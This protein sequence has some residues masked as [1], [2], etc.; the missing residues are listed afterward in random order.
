MLS[1][2]KAVLEF[3]EADDNKGAAAA[4]IVAGGSS[5]RMKGI[6]KITSG[7]LGVPVIARTLRAFQNSES[8]NKIILVA[9]REDIPQMQIIANNYLITKLSDIVCGG[10]SRQESVLNGIS[11]LNSTDKIVLIHDGA[12][13]LVSQKIIADVVE[14]TIRF[15]AAA[16]AV[17]LKDTIGHLSCDGF[18]DSTPNRAELR[19]MQTPQGFDRKLYVKSAKE[20]DLSKCT[21]DCS[22]VQAC[23]VK[24]FVT[25]GERCNIKITTPDDLALAELYLKMGGE[26]L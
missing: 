12:R 5:R 9:R 21:D 24:V 2:T 10:S 18:A 11:A 26:D 15:G 16:P 23:G 19:A 3:N 8:I 4:V 7:I 14:A 20:A 25:E 17:E 13:P 22:V 6:Q 1:E